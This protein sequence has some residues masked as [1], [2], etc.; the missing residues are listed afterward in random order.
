M[1]HEIT[2]R[3]NG[4]AEAMY[5]GL[6]PAWHGLGTVVDQAP[7]SADAMKLAGLM[8]EVEQHPLQAIVT[9]EEP[10]AETGQMVESIENVPVDDR[11]ANV[12]SDNHFVLGV[13]GKKYR[14][15]QNIEAFNF[16]DS[17]V[18]EQEIR[19]EAA[20]SLKG[21][22]VVWLLARMP[23]TIRIAKDD[24]T[25]QFIL[26]SNG[27]DGAKAI[28]VMPTSVRVVCQ[29]TLNLAIR[30]GERALTISHVGD[31]NRKLAA[32]REVLS[33]VKKQF[34]EF[35][36]EAA[37]MAEVG[38]DRAL[39]VQLVNELIPDDED[40]TKNN[41]QRIK[42]RDAILG[43]MTDG[44]QTLTGIRGTA[45]A[46]FNAVTHYV[47]HVARNTGK[48]AAAKSENR[49]N[50][51]VFGAGAQ[52]KAQGLERVRELAGLAAVD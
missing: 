51:I 4:R 15:C 35:G 2:V 36:Q 8:W 20:G 21:G 30:R 52:F 37:A 50:R 41:S 45:W 14:P 11:V 13:V 44:A 38:F 28:R 43:L 34:A 32:A 42:A 39:Q 27:H 23:E 48:T 49:M 46:A 26:F 24:I 29:N 31:V 12:R 33:L 22:K 40:K 19:Y 10:S 18:A 17:L 7:T 6:K 16:V 25:E 1:A 9:S 5:A 47:D 3:E